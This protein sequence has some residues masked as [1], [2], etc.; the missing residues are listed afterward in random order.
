M[1][2]HKY[3]I[4]QLYEFPPIQLF[5]LLVVTSYKHGGYNMDDNEIGVVLTVASVVQLLWQVN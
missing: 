4:F 5:P 1:M 3:I 2:I